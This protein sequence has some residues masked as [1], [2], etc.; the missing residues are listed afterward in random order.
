MS[1]RASSN[2][3]GFSLIAALLLM[4]LIS[5]LSVALM[6][7]VNYGAPDQQRRPGAESF[8][9][10]GR[11]RDGEDDRGRGQPLHERD[12][13]GLT[14]ISALGAAANQPAISGVQFTTI[15]Y[16]PMQTV[17][18]TTPAWTDAQPKPE[19]SYEDNLVRSEPGLYA[20]TIPIHMDVVAARTS[21]GCRSPHQA[22]R[23]G[24]SDSGIPV[25]RVLRF[26]PELLPWPGV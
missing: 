10:R 7:S 9:L 25:W 5:A 16:F 1:Q 20:Q 2:N 22:G 4:L 18:A 13:T 17:T 12:G 14:D 26:R 23:R 19:R 11:S 15:Q 8:A 21:T 3:R 24:R 6:Y